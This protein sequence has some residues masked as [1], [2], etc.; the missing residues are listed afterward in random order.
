M[1]GVFGSIFTFALGVLVPNTRSKCRF[2][3]RLAL[4]KV[5]RRGRVV[6]MTTLLLYSA[7]V[8]R[9][10]AGHHDGPA[11]WALRRGSSRGERR[12]MARRRRLLRRVPRPEAEKETV[13]RVFRNLFLIDIWMHPHLFIA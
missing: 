13:T 5:F 9:V 4:R 7:P 8:L 6:F 1:L 10:H 2:H 12:Q 11:T 3:R